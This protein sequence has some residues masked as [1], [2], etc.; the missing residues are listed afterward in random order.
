MLSSLLLLLEEEQDAKDKSMDVGEV[1]RDTVKVGTGGALL[2][3][4]RIVPINERFSDRDCFSV[5]VVCSLVLLNHR[6][7]FGFSQ[8]VVAK[9]S[10]MDEY[11]SCAV[12]VVVVDCFFS[13]C[14]DGGEGCPNM[15]PAPFVGK[16]VISSRLGNTMFS[17]TNSSIFALIA[18]TTIE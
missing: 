18:L 16:K 4:L 13:S 2:L 12:V 3:R 1:D 8:V 10:G 5:I 17:I 6:R 9:R 14:V 15:P 7:I 11:F